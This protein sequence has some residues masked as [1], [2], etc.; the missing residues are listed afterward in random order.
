MRN[1][2]S[3]TSPPA[4]LTPWATETESPMRKPDEALI[5][6]DVQNDFCP[7]GALAVMGGDEIIARVNALMTEFQTVVLTQDWHPANHS[8]FAANHPGAAP[9][10]LTEMPYGPQVLWP[11]HCAEGTA[12]AAFHPDLNT[13]PAQLVIRKGFRA[14]IDSYSAFFENDKTKA[15][16]FNAAGQM[17]RSEAITTDRQA[18]EMNHLPDG[19]YFLQIVSGQR[20]GWGKFAKY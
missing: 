18:F 20:V 9:F 12:G 17:V 15:R 14:G 4:P 3:L 2:R 7:G 8:S 11:T 16:I 19:A 1:C 5:V 10:S 6:I 13:D